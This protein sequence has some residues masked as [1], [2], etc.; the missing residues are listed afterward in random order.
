MTEDPSK[1][2][3]LLVTQRHELARRLTEKCTSR[4]DIQNRQ[5]NI[6]THLLELGEA[7][8]NSSRGAFV[9]HVRWARSVDSCREIDRSVLIGELRGLAKIVEECV[10]PSALPIV[11]E[12]LDAGLEQCMR[13]S[14]ATSD[15]GDTEC[16][17]TLC[18]DYTAA[19]LRSDRERAFLLVQRALESGESIRTIYLDVFQSSQNRVGLLWQQNR[20][21]VAQEHF[22]TAATQ[23]IMSRLYDY[24]FCDECNGL[25]FVGT[26]A[27]SELHELGIRMVCD[28]LEMDGWD[29]VYLG[30][31]TPASAVVESIERH[32]ADVLGVSATMAY[33]TQQV[34]EIV[35][36]VRDCPSTHDTRIVLGGYPFLRTSTLCTD[37]G[38]DGWARD[39]REAVSL[40]S[41]FAYSEPV[42]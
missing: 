29:T 35:R 9:H 37:L 27:G 25:R 42:G 11:R 1:T 22:C 34:A 39:A 21:S 33:H 36:A 3:D 16:C 5:K 23:Q 12:H 30:A 15:A 2:R 24:V 8:V 20:I 10:S 13:H 40:V 6:E 38:G 14:V 26:C 32:G 28:F 18:R 19:L 31:N 7:L 17:S 4:R 41:S